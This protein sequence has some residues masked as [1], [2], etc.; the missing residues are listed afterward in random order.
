M[1]SDILDA[2]E[3]LSKITK[4][5]YESLFRSKLEISFPIKENP[6]SIVRLMNH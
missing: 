4:S 5:V 2:V 6:R 1:K 3:N